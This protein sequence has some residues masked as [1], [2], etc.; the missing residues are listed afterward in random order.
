M[1]FRSVEGFARIEREREEA[2]RPLPAHGGQVGDVRHR[3][4]RLTE[5][6]R[7]VD[8]RA[9]E[10]QVSLLDRGVVGL[11]HL[12]EPGDGPALLLQET[13]HLLGRVLLA[14]TNVGDI[15]LDPTNL[16]QNTLTAAQRLADR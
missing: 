3:P 15:V 5:D 1:L 8:P 11:L 12:R 13:R 4:W 10:D 6:E 16:V 2:G 14:T 7:S 9:D